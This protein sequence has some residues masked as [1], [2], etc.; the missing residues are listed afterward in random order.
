MSLARRAKK[1]DTSE[2]GIRQ[3]LHAVGAKTKQT[4]LVD[5]I[6]LHR[7][8]LYLLEV[9]TGKGRLTDLQKALLA[10]GWP[11]Q[12]VSTPAQ[13]LQAIGLGTR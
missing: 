1:R 4:D 12:V 3:A 8:Q 13:A 5:L 6:V 10:E 2:T 7:Q 9:K 11:I